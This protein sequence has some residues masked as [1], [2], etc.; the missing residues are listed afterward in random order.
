MH[1]KFVA[2]G[3]RVLRQVQGEASREPSQEQR[4]NNGTVRAGLTSRREE[5]T[6]FLLAELVLLFC[7]WL[8]VLARPVMGF[9]AEDQAFC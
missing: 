2:G 1:Q 5:T 4:G 9:L 6:E 7:W 8:V 3:M